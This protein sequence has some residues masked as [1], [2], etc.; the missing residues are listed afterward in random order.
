MMKINLRPAARADYAQIADCVLYSH[1]LSAHAPLT[2]FFSPDLTTRAER[3]D[4]IIHEI[5]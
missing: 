3:N 5:K 4:Y 2:A 1:E